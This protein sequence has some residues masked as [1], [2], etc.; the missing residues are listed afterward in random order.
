[1]HSTN[2]TMRC[3]L[4]NVPQVLRRESGHIR[5]PMALS[6]NAKDT[7]TNMRPGRK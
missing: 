5:M 1:M 2:F 3:E 7:A 4:M 6:V